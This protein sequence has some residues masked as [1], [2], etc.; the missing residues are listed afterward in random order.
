MNVTSGNKRKPKAGQ[1]FVV[2]QLDRKQHTRAGAIS[3]ARRRLN[4]RAQGHSHALLVVRVEAVV[5]RKLIPAITVEEVE[6]PKSYRRKEMV[7]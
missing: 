3:L 4:C 1:F 5:R 2:R 7:R 6:S